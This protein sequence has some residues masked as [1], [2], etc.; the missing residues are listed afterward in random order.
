MLDGHV[1]LI[2]D[3]RLHIGIPDPEECLKVTSIGWGIAGGCRSRC[4]QF[5]L[6]YW[7]AGA[8]RRYRWRM[9]SAGVKGGLSVKRRFVPVPSRYDEIVNAPRITVLPAQRRGSPRETDAWLEVPASIEALVECA[10]GPVLAG[11]VDIA[12][13]NVVIGLLVVGFRPGRMRIVAQ[14][15]IQALSVRD[16][17]CVLGID[18]DDVAGLLPS[19]AGTYSATVLIVETENKIGATVTSRTLRIAR[20]VNLP[21]K[22]MRPKLT[23]VTG[24]EGLDSLVNN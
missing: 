23:V 16:A 6:L 5:H 4:P 21:S 17:P 15:E 7:S 13:S 24:V 8:Q 11:E 14:T 2:R 18:S 19:L 9:I 10:T 1:P 22:S 12:G 3:S 20:L